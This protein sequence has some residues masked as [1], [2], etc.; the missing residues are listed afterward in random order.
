MKSKDDVEKIKMFYT[1][2]E[3]YVWVCVYKLSEQKEETKK[4]RESEEEEIRCNI[5][6]R[7]LSIWML[8]Y[9]ES[10]VLMN[11]YVCFFLL[12]FFS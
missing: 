7:I 8:R 12:F 11:V 9:R 6:I 2:N 4:E 1:P 3:I 10:D 5:H